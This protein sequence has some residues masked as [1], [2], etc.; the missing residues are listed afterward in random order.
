M[1]GDFWSGLTAGMILVP[2]IVVAVGAGIGAARALKRAIVY[3]RPAHLERRINLAGRFVGARRAYYLGRGRVS[4]ALL[5]GDDY[6]RSEQAAAVLHDE[7][8][9]DRTHS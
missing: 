5:I 3:A 2:I 4:V 9:L 8:L 1:S 6:S 7:F